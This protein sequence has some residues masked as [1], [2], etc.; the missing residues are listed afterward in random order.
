MTECW[1]NGL[2]NIRRG[3]IV[4]ITRIIP[5]SGPTRVTV[6]EN[7]TTGERRTSSDNGSIMTVSPVTLPEP[8]T[9]RVASVSV[10]GNNVTNFVI[11][12]GLVRDHVFVRAGETEQAQQ[13][14]ADILG[15]ELNGYVKIVDPY[16]SPVT[17]RMLR[18][19]PGGVDILLL[20]ENISDLDAA[21]REAEGLSLTIKRA[22]QL[23][24][25]FILTSGLGWSVGHSLKDLGTRMSSI[26]R[27]VSSVDAESEFDRLWNAA[28]TV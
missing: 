7:V 24:D 20:T 15:R 25:R 19:V 23:H 16:V 8:I 10:G 2:V 27:L 11:E 21:L 5:G 18:S 14:L 3:D 4:T 13:A 12:E 6:M 17:V 9:G 22:T 26:S 1:F 28:L